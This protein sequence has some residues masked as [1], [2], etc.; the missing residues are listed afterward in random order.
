[1]YSRK[2]TIYEGERFALDS[3]GNG[4]AYTLRNK[5]ALTSVFLQDD[6]A[7]QF[8]DELDAQE[9][10]HPHRDPDRLL[11]WLWNEC[12]YGAAAQSDED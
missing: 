5:V 2:V 11:S 1:M 10:A 9:A 4:A 8:R 6:A 3:Y 7:G 12:E